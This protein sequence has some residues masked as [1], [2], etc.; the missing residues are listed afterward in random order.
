MRKRRRKRRRR[1]R[2]RRREGRVEIRQEHGIIR[3]KERRKG[4]KYV[5]TNVDEGNG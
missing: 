4:E 2:R 5:R 1:V 3:R